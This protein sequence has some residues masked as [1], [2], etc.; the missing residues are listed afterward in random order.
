M[1]ITGTEWLARPGVARPGEARPGRA[2]HR[3]RGAARPGMAGPGTAGKAW[4]GG[5]RQGKAW[6]GGPWRGTAPLAWRGAAGHAEEWRGTAPLA[7]Q[8]LARR[9][10]AGRRMPWHHM[11]GAGFGW[12]L[13]TFTSELMTTYTFRPNIPKPPVPAQLVGDTL[14][15]IEADHGVIDSRV[16]LDESR[17][18]DA[19]LHPCFD[20]DDASAAEKYRLE[21]SRALIRSVEIVHEAPESTGLAFV[22][23]TSEG[24]YISA[25]TMQQRSDLYEE[26]DRIYRSRVEAAAS[27]LR[28]LES[29]APSNRKARI[30]KD[31]R[32]LEQLALAGSAS[33]S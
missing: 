18:E 32:A 8:G 20:W 11:T 2:R 17:P 12:P 13:L 23:V 3:W 22:H 10:R 27:Q 4:H 19:P 26:A 29:L 6:P 1:R 21:Q 31:L 16:V 9:A 5:A 15:Q 25:A 24:G 30:R 28:K 7:R 14:E 33:Q